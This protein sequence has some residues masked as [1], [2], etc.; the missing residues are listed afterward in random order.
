M[1]ISVDP[2]KGSSRLNADLDADGDGT[3]TAEEEA[4][5]ATRGF[6]GMDRAT[7][8]HSLRRTTRVRRSKTASARSRCTCTTT[9]T[10]IKLPANPPENPEN[11][12]LWAGVNHAEPTAADLFEQQL[13]QQGK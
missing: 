8:K 13:A 3:I 9:Y 1:P 2:F 7:T 12:K 5:R 6:V 10:N 4:E 11:K